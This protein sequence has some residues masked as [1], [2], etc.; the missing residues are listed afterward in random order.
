MYLLDTN[1]LIYHLNGYEKATF[2]LK[3][4]LDELYIS[5]ITECEVLALPKLSIEEINNIEQFIK[6][7]KVINLDS[8]IA[9]KAAEIKRKYSIKIG[10]ALIAATVIINDYTLIT[11][12][13]DD[14]KNI[15]ELKIQDF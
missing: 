1:I 14:F 4:H 5:V 6:L 13:I 7:F 11:R 12:N 9:Q 10:D 15:R 2:L 8:K 3:E